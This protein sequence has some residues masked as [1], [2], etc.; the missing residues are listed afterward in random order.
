MS[1]I[2]KISV[3]LLDMLC[4]VLSLYVGLLTFGLER[5]SIISCSYALK[6]CLRRLVTGC[7]P[8]PD[9]GRCLK[10]HRSPW[11]P[12]GRAMMGHGACTV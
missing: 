3:A 11:R 9:R 7:R 8:L 6:T 4:I 10:P 1:A 2:K 5:A 12:L